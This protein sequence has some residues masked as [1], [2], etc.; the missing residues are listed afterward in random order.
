MGTHRA[1]D[2]SESAEAEL[3]YDSA[4]TSRQLDR[5]VRADRHLAHSGVV[6]DAEHQSEEGSSEDVIARKSQLLAS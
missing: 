4:S 2:V 1:Y 6:D 3:A 5:G